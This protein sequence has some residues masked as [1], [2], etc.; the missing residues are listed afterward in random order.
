MLQK[1]YSESVDKEREQMTARITAVEAKH[2]TLLKDYMVR[3]QSTN[4]RAQPFASCCT[5]HTLLWLR[6]AEA[7]ARE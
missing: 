1:R 3:L 5:H 4:C 7:Y 6:I 2:E